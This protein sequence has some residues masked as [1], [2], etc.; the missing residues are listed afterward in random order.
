MN[1]AADAATADADTATASAFDTAGRRICCSCVRVA[2]RR[3]MMLTRQS[4]TGT[5][6]D[7]ILTILG[8]VLGK[9]RRRI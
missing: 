4:L 5:L 2:V 3:K 1:Y 6:V 7:S 9:V 8:D